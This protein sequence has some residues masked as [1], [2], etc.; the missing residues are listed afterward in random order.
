MKEE[1][2]YFD[3]GRTRLT[4]DSWAQMNANSHFFRVKVDLP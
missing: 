4:D 2:F 1:R 3:E